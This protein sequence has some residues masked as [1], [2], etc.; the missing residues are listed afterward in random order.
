MKN[1]NLINET[2]SATKCYADQ[3]LYG[4]LIGL[5]IVLIA[6]IGFLLIRKRCSHN[7]RKVTK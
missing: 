6:F 3:E 4:S 7:K 5:A 2:F 1:C